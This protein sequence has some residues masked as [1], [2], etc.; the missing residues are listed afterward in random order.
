MARKRISLTL[1][2]ELVERIDREK[3]KKKMNNRS[4]AIEKFLKEH[5]KS[6]MVEK[7]VILCGGSEETPSCVKKI[8]SIKIIDEKLKHLENSGVK[9]VYIATN[10]DAEKMREKINEEK[11]GLTIYYSVEDNPLGT[12]GCLRKLGEHLKDTFILTNG[13]VICNIDVED[14]LKIH[15]KNRPEATMALTTTDDTSK[16]GVVNM[17]GNKVVGFKEKPEEAATKLINA[18]FYIIEPSIIGRIKDKKTEKVAIETI[19]EELS[20]KDLLKGYLYEG[21]WKDFGN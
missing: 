1:D 5:F 19:F 11:Y 15:R 17:K 6:K 7:A 21:E 13:D 10:Q 2:E 16:Y 18:G 14:M 12:A 8:K 3:E 20:E 4:R 9:T